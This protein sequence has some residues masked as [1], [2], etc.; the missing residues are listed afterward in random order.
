MSVVNSRGRAYSLRFGAVVSGETG[1]VRERSWYEISIQYLKAVQAGH[2]RGRSSLA[3]LKDKF[4]TDAQDVR[5]ESAS[6]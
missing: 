2:R 1:A 6:V 3:D 5:D 4:L